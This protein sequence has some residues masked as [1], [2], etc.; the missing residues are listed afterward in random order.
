MIAQ[1]GG[2]RGTPASSPA[3]PGA[4]PGS[5]FT[6][7]R[8]QEIPALRLCIEEYR[9]QATGALHLHLAADSMEN[10]FLVGL[11]TA[12]D[13][14]TGVAHIL[15]HTALCG[16][17]RYPVRDP[18][19]MMLRRSLST[20]MNAF[21]SSDW[22]A[23]PFATRNR[24]DFDNLLQ[25]YLD[26]VF[27][28]K[29][30]ALDFAQEGHRMEFEQLDN[31][32]T[33]LVYRGVVYNEMLGAMSS[34]PAQLWQALCR[35]LHPDTTYRY[36]SGGDPLEIPALQHTALVDF[37]R[38]HY[39]PGNATFMTYG[40]IPAAEHQ[41]H[42]EEHVL[43][44]F[45]A[46]AEQFQV[47][48]ETRF[49]APLCAQERYM[50]SEAGNGAD[51]LKGR[52]HILLAW[53]LGDASSLEQIARANLLHGILL[54]N[55]AS[56]LRQ[57]L[58][59]TRLG[60]APS[61]LCGL[62]DGQ[63][64]LCLVCGIEGSEPE[65]AGALEQ[66]VLDT[67]SETA[68]KGVPQEMTEAVLHQF[69]LQHRE[70]GGDG[71][72]YGLQL[73]MQCLP[74]A[75]HHGDPLAVLNLEPVLQQLRDDIGDPQFVPRLVREQLLDNPHRL[76]LVMKPD[77]GLRSEREQ[78]VQERLA[79]V[80]STLSAEDC[81]ELVEKGRALEQRQKHK[82]DPEV[83]PRLRLHDAPADIEELQPAHGSAGTL[84]LR[85]YACGSNGIAYQQLVFDLPE[86][87]R[88]QQF[89]LPLY[90]RFLG[91][92]GVGEQDYLSVQKRQAAICSG[93]SAAVLQR[94]TVADPQRVQARFVLSSHALL[95]NHAA[96]SALLRQT[97]DEVR[98]DELP[99]LRELLAQARARSEELLTDHGHRLAM[100][101]ALSGM[102]PGAVLAHQCSG[103]E[104]VRRLKQLDRDAAESDA[105]QGLAGQLAAIH[106]ALRDMPLQA[107]LIAEE[108]ALA[109]CTQELAAQWPGA[110][111][112]RAP[113]EALLPLPPVRERISQVWRLDTQVHFCARAWP[114]VPPTHAD[115]APL[116]VL[117][118]F[119][120]H[121]YLHPAIREQGGAYGGG[122]RYSGDHAAFC[123]FSYRD[124][125]LA[126]TLEDFDRALDWL[127]QTRHQP[128]QLEEAI[129]SVI[130]ALDKP[131]SPAGEAQADFHGRLFG[132]G[133]Q[134]RRAFRKAVLNTRMEDLQRVG[135]AWLRP[136]NAS[137][138]VIVP[139]DAELP[140][141]LQAEE[142]QL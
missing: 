40:N 115:A 67:L 111:P 80:R 32:D 44:H 10:A 16:S 19:F 6:P 1:H 21:T 96:L 108:E 58:E 81:Q 136:E 119:L 29:L 37:H 92:L 48:L 117:A 142:Y 79:A 52:T 2:R 23:Y 133:P 54:D 30:D 39:H 68:E 110:A 128:L 130:A 20:F 70:I 15:E 69:E 97:L 139:R 116:C 131:G 5:G 137:T 118:E 106:G 138:A 88:E 17:Q 141:Q 28:P 104:G 47:P 43:Q 77:P 105:L 71:F 26:A 55:S 24:R 22:T 60:N 51:A 34:T 65:H 61:S 99:R 8:R 114:A 62:E 27:F 31:P 11:R 14:S 9:H 82:D 122:A 103:L 75:I 90:A 74:A 38:R 86:L 63:R 98:F 124:P 3:S 73:M 4:A 95:R 33:P 129:L 50:L 84:P 94:G 107:L 13:D 132:R 101:A 112:A 35:H 113:G 85:Y 53:L 45:S 59:T 18:F 36:N 12:P 56:P 123:C 78:Q 91:E 140:P 66:E 100:G 93:V 102:S 109:A 49:Q 120:R 41:A 125:R 42:L 57:L 135:T 127:Q 25:V 134:Y 76:R 64:E 7:G 121:G 83:L 89:L 87:P 126:A 72:P 46:P